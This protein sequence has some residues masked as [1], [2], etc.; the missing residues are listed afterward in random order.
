MALVVFSG[1]GHRGILMSMYTQLLEA[2]LNEHRQPAVAPTAVEALAALLHCGTRLG[3]SGSLERRLD[4]SSIALANQVAYDIALIELARCVGIA[5]DPG[6][7]DQPVRRRNELTRELESRCIHLNEL[8][9][10]ADYAL[11]QN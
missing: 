3:S 6:T 7:F 11:E 2:A 8:D 9:Q 5:C 4:W 1:K 10:R